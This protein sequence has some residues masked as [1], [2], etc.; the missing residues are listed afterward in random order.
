MPGALSRLALRELAAW[1]LLCRRP[2]LAQ[3]CY[4]RILR[5]TPDDVATLAARAYLDAASTDPA[6]RARAV[7]GFERVLTL[8]PDD[9]ESWFSLGFLRQRDGA[10]RAALDAFAAALRLRPGHDRAWY[11]QG[12]SQA[13][14]GDD[15]A[16]MASLQRVTGLQPMS[17]D[18]YVALAR[19]QWRLRR[20]DECLHTVHALQQFDP[21]QAT[22]LADE[23]DIRGRL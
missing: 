12:L 21:Q 18:G 7:A 6:A 14:L 2:T 20:I 9:A 8:Q 13:A 16:A 11:G 1:A 10:H 15:V 23:L 19:C 5:S 3:R 17:A 4:A 22:R